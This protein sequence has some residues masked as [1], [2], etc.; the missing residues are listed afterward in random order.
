MR[1][2]VTRSSWSAILVATA[3]L[4]ASVAIL[5]SADRDTPRIDGRW[6]LN[7]A[8]SQIPRDVGFN[9]EGLPAAG[10]AG[11]ATTG[12]GRGSGGRGRR[13]SSGGGATGGG[14]TGDP[15][16]A[17]PQSADD[18]SRVR[19]LTAEV[20]NPPAHLTIVE[21]QDAV[22]IADDRGHPRTFRTDGREAVLQ[23]DDVSVRVSSTLEG[24]TFVVVYHVEPNHDLRYSYTGGT[25]PAQLIVDIQFVERGGGDSIRLVYEPTSDTER[26]TPAPFSSPSKPASSQAPASAG[27]A[28]ASQ[29]FNQRPD[30]ELTGLNA[31]GLVVEDLSAQATACG[32]NKDAIESALSERLSKAG[33]KVQRNADEDTY[34]YVHII[35]TGPSNG[36]CVSR[37]DA[38]L[39]THTTA[40]L[41]YQSKP[42]LVQVE[43]MHKGSLTG[44]ALT[45]HPGGVLRA[46]Q[47]YVDQFTTRISNANK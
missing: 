12:G 26:A 27:P 45:S 28:A 6:T 13:G 47:E 3:F 43:L 8:L 4:A 1:Q 35:T 23:L 46:L 20:R 18:A 2:G 21:A 9:L 17:R 11:P 22:T 41:S 30:A 19:Q 24:G 44:S 33:L 10:G 34:L 36:L 7:R 14:V 32:L 16:R 29:P 42:V 5:R 15:F 39:Y 37:Y 38:F 31:L 40:T 25:S